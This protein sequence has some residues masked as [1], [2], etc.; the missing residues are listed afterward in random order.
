MRRSVYRVAKPKLKSNMRQ[1]IP[2]GGKC[3]AM[4]VDELTGEYAGIQSSGRV[5]LVTMNVA[6]IRDRLGHAAKRM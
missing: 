3:R 5:Q 4:D 1:P 6:G 2:R